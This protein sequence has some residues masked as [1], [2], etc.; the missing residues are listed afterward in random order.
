MSL[1]D[2]LLPS[3]RPITAKTVHPGNAFLARVLLTRWDATTNTF[4][5]LTGA[6]ITCDWALD[7]NNT[8]P[9]AALQGIPLL[10]VGA[11][12][13]G[14]YAEVIPGASMNALNALVGQ[15][16]YQLTRNPSGDVLTATA[17]FVRYPRWAQ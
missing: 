12:A 17:R 11:V 8:V 13:P 7:P 6:A 4:T 10:E 16:V 14:V 3:G 5:P 15:T 9:I 1:L 2:T